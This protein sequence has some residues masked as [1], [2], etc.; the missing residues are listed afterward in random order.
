[1]TLAAGELGPPPKGAIAHQLMRDWLDW[2]R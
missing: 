1:V 2:T